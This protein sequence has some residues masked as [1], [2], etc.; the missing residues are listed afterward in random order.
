MSNE[1]I[2][3]SV[4]DE[5]ARVIIDRVEKRNAMSFAMWQR[6]PVLIAEAAADRS[7][8][9]IVLQGADETAFAAGADIEE[10]LTLI[11]SP[12]GGQELMDA[13]RSAEQ[14]LGNCPK[15]VIAMIRGL[16]VGGGIE[17][18]LACD[19]RFASRGTRFAIPPAR[20]GLVY[21]A[22]ST[23]R[24]IELAG[25]GKARDLL[26]SGRSFDSAEARE[27]GLIEREFSEDEIE[28]QTIRYAKSLCERS[29]YSIRAAKQITAAVRDGGSDEDDPIRRLRIGAFSNDDLKE[30]ARAFL[31]KRSPNFTC[32]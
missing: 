19:L 22:S 3:L 16:C 31:E 20:L 5:I 10:I 4:A 18:A 2:H 17:L 12:A 27:M 28:A 30:G 1:P 25:I 24:L 32:R 7:A 11:D 8:K 9:V 6:L 14:A 29:Q 13:V 15:P 23:R 21:S 26:Y